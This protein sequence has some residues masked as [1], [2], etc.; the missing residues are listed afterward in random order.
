[1]KKAAGSGQWG[2]ITMPS[3]FIRAIFLLSVVAV[4]PASAIDRMLAISAPAEAAAGGHVAVS[5]LASTNAVDGEEI[6]FLHAEYSVDAGRTW[7]PITYDAKAGPSLSR[8]ISFTVG[9]KGVRAV[10]RVRA[11]FR[12]GQS[13]DV[14]HKGNPTNREGTW[15]KWL[16]PATKVA[17][18]YVK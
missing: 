18:I 1:L 5:V 16:A 9:A 2:R 10:V 13:G 6:G 3:S 12:G 11:A 7:T 8:K 15:D 14:D 17:V 4:A